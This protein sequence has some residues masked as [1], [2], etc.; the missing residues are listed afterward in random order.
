M[1]LAMLLCLT[2]PSTSSDLCGLD[3]N[4]RRYIPEGV[5]F[6]ASCLA[7]QSK[8]TKPRTEFFFPGFSESPHLCPTTTLRAYE[9]RTRNLRVTDTQS[10]LFLGVIRPHR[11]VA[12]STIAR[13]LRTVMEK[14][15]I[16][17]S[18]FKAHST[19]GAATTAAANAGITT[20][21]ILTDYT[22]G[23]TGVN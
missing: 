23:S 14:A 19:R 18:V 9:D 16:D 4:F 21:D 8:T 20:E 17:T 13:W 2:R 15:G 22:R 6:Q 3:L 5:T 11:P 7:K 10:K 1:K 12:P